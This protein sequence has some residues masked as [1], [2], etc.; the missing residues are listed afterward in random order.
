ME[1]GVHTVNEGASAKRGENSYGRKRTKQ[2][3]FRHGWRHRPLPK[4]TWIH[5]NEATKRF[6]RHSQTKPSGSAS[7]TSQIIFL[8][9]KECSVNSTMKGHN[10]GFCRKCGK[11]HKPQT[12]PRKL[13]SKPNCGCASCKA[14]RGEFKGQ[15][16]PMFGRVSARKGKKISMST[17]RLMAEAKRKWHREH[18]I[19][20]KNHPMFGKH[21]SAQTREKIRKARLGQI[22]P[23]R[24]TSIEKLVHKELH[25]RSIPFTKHYIFGNW[26]ID[27]AFIVQKI[28]VECDGDYWHSLPNRK[29]RDS[30]LDVFIIKKGWMIIHLQEHDIKQNVGTCV[31]KIEELLI[32]SGLAYKAVIVEEE[33]ELEPSPVSLQRRCVICDAEFISKLNTPRRKL[34]GSKE[35]ARKDKQ[36]YYLRNIARIKKYRFDNREHLLQYDR[37]RHAKEKQKRLEVELCVH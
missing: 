3:G 33:T 30:D 27:I 6:S 29:K 17:K 22:F 21:P 11:Y 9:V 26:Q 34:C 5:H 24:D 36:L 35:C 4:Q 8:W 31:N 10:Y 13:H 37:D 12:G 15:G 20:G 28:L 7:D 19:S 23:T 25:K 18:D 16:H 32:A 1:Q 2:E 14:K